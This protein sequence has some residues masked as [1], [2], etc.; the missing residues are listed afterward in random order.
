MD[1]WFADD[2]QCPLIAFW[3]LLNQVLF[4]NYCILC[5]VM[6]LFALIFIEGHQS[7]SAS[8]SFSAIKALNDK[9]AS[10]LR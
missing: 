1:V 5:E 6:F 2:I 9:A 3:T 7:F 4:A 8:I 10:S